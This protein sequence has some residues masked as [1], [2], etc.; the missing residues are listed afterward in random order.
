MAHDALEY[1]RLR[2]DARELALDVDMATD[3]ALEAIARQKLERVFSA[4]ADGTSSS[5]SPARVPER[6]GPAAAEL[7]SIDFLA[8]ILRPPGKAA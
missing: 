6:Q 1:E 5:S 8:P 3:G 7:P 2:K 4:I